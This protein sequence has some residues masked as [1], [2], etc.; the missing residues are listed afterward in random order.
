MYLIIRK[1]ML[2]ADRKKVFLFVFSDQ[3]LHLISL[4]MSYLV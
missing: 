1:M 4:E 2:L 3:S